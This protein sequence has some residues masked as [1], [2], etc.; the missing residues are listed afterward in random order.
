MTRPETAS[1]LGAHRAT[2]EPKPEPWIGTS[3]A[4]A[5]LVLSLPIALIG[6]VWLALGYA[7]VLAVYGWVTWS[8][9]RHA[10]RGKG[11]R[12]DVFARG[13]R[14][15][16]PGTNVFEFRWETLSFVSSIIHSHKNGT[17]ESTYVYAL[18][19]DDRRVLIIGDNAAAPRTH[20]FD[21]VETVRGPAFVDP[22][23]WGG[24]IQ[25]RTAAVQLPRVARMI[26]DG[27]TVTFGPLQVTAHELR[28]AD[29]DAVPWSRIDRFRLYAGQLEVRA[30]DVKRPLLRKRVGEVP[31]FPVFHALAESLRERAH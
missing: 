5:A 3:I 18:M 24:T 30:A 29:G 4:G 21:A 7:F 10:A 2:Y 11:A 22:K 25:R 26:E 19:G 15:T 20:F 1:P 6:T 16:G 8:K 9:V 28:T 12:L 14:V 31:N 27:R 13:L 17:V 23:S